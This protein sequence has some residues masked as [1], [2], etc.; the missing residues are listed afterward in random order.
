L[1]YGALADLKFQ[2]FLAP[3]KNRYI[4]V[5]YLKKYTPTSLAIRQTSKPSN[6]PEFL[7]FVTG[8]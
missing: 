6:E 1:F 3:V 2:G 7:D 4:L 8:G 5:L